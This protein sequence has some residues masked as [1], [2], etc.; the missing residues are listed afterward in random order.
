MANKEIGRIGQRRYGG[1][2]Y[3][4]FLHELRGTRGIEVY[5]EMSEN[6]DVVGAIL[7][8]IEMLVRQCDWNIE[9]GG[10]TA[11]DKEAAEFVESCMHD[12]QDTWTDIISEILSFLTYGWSFHEI[13]YKRRMGNTK[14]PTTK[15]KYTDGLI[16]WKKLPIRAQ[17]TLYRWEY[18][19]EDNLLGMTQMPPPDFGTY[20]IPMSKAL[21]FR[22]KSRKNNP[23]GRSILR[24][25]YRS[26]YFKRRIQEIEGIGIERDLAGLPVMHAPEGLDIWDDAI[27]E[28]KRT[29]IALENMVK[30][31]RRDE[32][33]GVVLPAGYELELLSSGGTRQFDTN[34]IINR[35]DTRIAMTVLADFIFL[36]HS[37]TGSWAL[38]SDK[39]E[40]FAMAI[41]AFLDII[42]ETFNSQGIPALI[43]INGEHFK[44]ITDY[45]KMT[46]GDIEDADITKVSTFV[47]DMTGIGILVPDDGLEDYIRQVGNLPERTTDD[48][49]VD[50]RRK[51]QAEQNQPPEPE[52][53]V[54]S[55]G[56]DEGEEIPDNV[57]E[58]AKRR[59]GRSGTNGN[60]VHTAKANTQGKDTEQSRSPTQT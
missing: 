26:W 47:K 41:G 2:I 52:T 11:K 27:D 35:Y 39:T 3:E 25:A 10:D 38:S 30:S 16:G 49:T 50:Q 40:L 45:P 32:M 9:P 13:V 8:A 34:A 23:E 59:L 44:C 24:N 29:R 15:S 54:G 42:C 18:D 33:E 51:Q 19:N 14:N 17:E 31:I 28:N 12:M 4:E 7:F 21:L 55:D 46:H 56:N 58:A 37:E 22:T 48:R 5:R 60:K 20:T 53:A 36:G 57:V 43:D 1:T 6:D